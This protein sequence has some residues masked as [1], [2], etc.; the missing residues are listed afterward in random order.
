MSFVLSI[1]LSF[2]VTT[3][4][5]VGKD[6]SDNHFYKAAIVLSCGVCLCDVMCVCVFY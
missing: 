3:K 2:R 5:C 1:Q 4:K 6:I